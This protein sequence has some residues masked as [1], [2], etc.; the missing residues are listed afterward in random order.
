[1]LRAFKY[2]LLPTT[3]QAD[4]FRRTIGCARFV[5]NAL[6]DD[7]KTQ[8][9]VYHKN[10][11]T[12]NK[13]IIREVSSLKTTSPWLNEVDSLALA[14]AKQNLKT[15]FTNFFNS[16]NGK[17]KGRKIGFPK[18]HKKSKCKLSYTTNNQGGNI[19]IE[20]DRICIP[21]IKWVKFNKHRECDGQ[22][23][24]ITI[25]QERN[26]DFYISVL[27]ETER[28]RKTKTNSNDLR[29]VGL[30]MSFSDFV[31]DSDNTVPDDMKPKYIRQYRANE[32][33]RAR[34]NRALSR[35]TKG[36]NNRNK[37][38]IRLAN[39]DRHIANCRQD[40]CHKTSKYYA[41]NYDVV[42]IEDLNMQDQAKSKMKGHGKSANDLG[43]GMFRTYLEY[44]CADY[45]TEFVVADKWFPSSKTCNHCGSVN[46]NL[47]LDDREWV[48]PECGVI[49]NRDY[50]AA[51]NLRDYYFSHI[52]TVGT[53]EI[54]A[55]GDST[56]TLG[57]TPTRVESLKQ[58]ASSFMEG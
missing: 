13:P 56:S 57:E 11:K 36:S 40:F 26:G 46:K 24:S 8:L 35:K 49:I 54:Y 20:D 9:D 31:V 14:N 2:R 22:I 39:L 41:S 43:F 32:K 19:R 37:A 42:V 15:A 3:E 10:G 25:T 27:C 55:C 53:T 7:Y 5:Y 30:D 4:Y 51:C 38:R 1:M 6:L 23:R 21:K 33:K 17:R 18:P 50:N 45:G 28:Q 34:L 44:K 12:G 29:V 48:C 52:N 16:R 58:E 47:K